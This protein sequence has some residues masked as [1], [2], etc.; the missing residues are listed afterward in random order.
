MQND[1][2][3]TSSNGD[4]E[5]APAVS[6]RSMLDY[7]NTSSAV[8][9]IRRWMPPREKA[10]DAMKTLAWVIPLTL[11][12]WIY[13]EQEQVLQTP[14]SVGNVPVQVKMTDG[15]Y[16]A[17]VGSA[18]PTVSTVLLK[19]TG[20][21]EAVQRVREALTN[22]IGGHPLT[23]YLDNRPNENNQP[24]NVVDAIQDQ[25]IFRKNGVTVKESI[26]AEIIVN[27]D[28]MDRATLAVQ[29]K[30]GVANLSPGSAFDPP[31]VDVIGPEKVLAP[32]M[33]ADQ[34]KVYADLSGLEELKHPG[35]HRIP[36][37][38]VSLSLLEPELR[39]E[40]YQ[41]KATV[42][43]LLS[44]K[45]DVIG[46]IPIEV[47]LPPGMVGQYDLTLTSGASV[48]Q[49]RVTGPQ[50]DIDAL[51]TVTP[52]AILDIL[53]SDARLDEPSKHLRFELPPSVKVTDDPALT[54]EFKLTKQA[55][56][57]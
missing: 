34:L 16:V 7:A 37:V 22:T 18:D 19:L 40:P 51:K 15:R 13:A 9:R 32:L 14:A 50:Q 21:Q 44:D 56:R 33:A 39:I 48:S 53:P 35:E 45:S 8:D 20:P 49:I 29:L 27:V 43:V 38:P 55:Q 1:A 24:I 46:P 4:S 28:K 17:V 52:K 41:V 25:D 5:K 57:D 2:D 42:T 23:A 11:I 47:Q 36:S 6:R 12:I 3:K 30:P 10:I 54:V 26:P 31:K